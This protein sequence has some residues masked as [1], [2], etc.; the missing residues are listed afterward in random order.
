MANT[1]GK[2]DY[3]ITKMGKNDP[4]PFDPFIHL[5][6]KSSGGTTPDGAP[7]LSPNLMTDREI[8]EYIQDLK[9]DLDAVGS[10]AKRALAAAKQ[11]TRELVE[12]RLTE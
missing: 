9:R 2:F 6:L 4:V 11:R 7:T 12:Q 3:D 1:I 10:K 5:C 8:D